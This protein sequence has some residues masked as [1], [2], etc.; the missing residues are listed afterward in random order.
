VEGTLRPQA[1]RCQ[2][3]TRCHPALL[4]PRTAQST[5]RVQIVLHAVDAFLTRSWSRKNQRSMGR[6]PKGLS[7]DQPIPG[8]AP[9]RDESSSDIGGVCRF[10]ENQNVRRIKRRARNARRR[11]KP[12]STFPRDWKPIRG[13][14][15][16]S[17][18]RG[19]IDTVSLYPMR[20][21]LRRVS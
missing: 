21:A 14:S 18:R 1:L 2:N 9:R 12:V 19:G 13:L 17:Y 4:P 8:S 7:G 16:A 3:S 20:I 6:G 11:R 15:S 5:T 10:L